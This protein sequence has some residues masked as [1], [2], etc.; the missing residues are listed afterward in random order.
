LAHRATDFRYAR[1]KAYRFTLQMPA[2]VT[3]STTGQVLPEV[4]GSN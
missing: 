4:N 3:T 1:L 2:C